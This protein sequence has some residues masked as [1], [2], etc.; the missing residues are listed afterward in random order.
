M[1]EHQTLPDSH[2]AASVRNTFF[3]IKDSYKNLPFHMPQ[4]VKSLPS[5]ILEKGT[6]FWQSLLPYSTPT[7]PPPPP[8]GI[9]LCH[10]SLQ[11]TSN[12]SRLLLLFSV[13]KN[14]RQ[15]NNH[16]KVYLQPGFRTKCQAISRA[17]LPCAVNV[18]TYG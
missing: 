13:R 6:H 9:N 16:W 14:S 1:G 3:F 18:A 2:K 15:G 12:I 10:Y 5:K 4:L 7:P 17:S 8:R 11:T